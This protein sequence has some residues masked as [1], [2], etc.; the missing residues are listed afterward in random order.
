M[1]ESGHCTNIEADFSKLNMIPSSS[2]IGE[3]F[4][5]NEEVLTPDSTHNYLP[6]SY[7]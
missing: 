5:E 6:G 3:D 4:P 1:Q 2:D 7:R